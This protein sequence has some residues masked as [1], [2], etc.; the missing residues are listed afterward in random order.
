MWFSSKNLLEWPE[1][2]VEKKEMHF[3]R[4]D[5]NPGFQNTRFWTSQAM[6]II[7]QLAV[8]DGI[9]FWYFCLFSALCSGVVTRLWTFLEALKCLKVPQFDD[10]LKIL[11]VPGHSETPTSYALVYYSLCTRPCT[12]SYVLCTLHYVLCSMYP[13]LRTMCYVP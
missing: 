8:F 2:W 3:S 7:G 6:W 5:V 1:V 11:V 4:A 9:F 13:A 12:T 10:F